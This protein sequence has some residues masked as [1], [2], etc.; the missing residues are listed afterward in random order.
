MVHFKE[1]TNIQTLV[2][3]HIFLHTW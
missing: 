2:A 1:R 3:V